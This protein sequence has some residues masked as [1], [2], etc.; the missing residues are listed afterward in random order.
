MDPSIADCR[1]M[2]AMNARLH[3]AADGF[4]PTRPNALSL[5]GWR[6]LAGKCRA[7]ADE[8]SAGLAGLIDEELE[9]LGTAWPSAAPRGL[10]HADLFPDNVFFDGAKVSGIIDFYFACTDFFVYDLAITLNAWSAAG[11]PWDEGRAQALLGGYNAERPLSRAERNALP[12]CLRGASLRILLT[13]LHDWLHRVDDAVVTVKDPLEYRDLL[14]FHR[15]GG[16]AG[17]LG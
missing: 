2:G 11:G 7:R 6:A 9:F 13:R 8:A 17:L 14:L 4:A 15:A 1:A 12:I 16:A 5:G 10:V 3:L